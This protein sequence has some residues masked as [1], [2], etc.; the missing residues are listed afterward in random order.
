MQAG[1]RAAAPRITLLGLPSDRAHSGIPPLL[2]HLF[3]GDSI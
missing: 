1:R 2:L 3:T